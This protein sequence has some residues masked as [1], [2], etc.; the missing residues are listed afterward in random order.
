MFSEMEFI[1]IF[2]SF[3][4][5]FLWKLGWIIGKHSHSLFLSSLFTKTVAK[6]HLFASL[7]LP[8]CPDVRTPRT[9]ELVFIKF[10]IEFCYNSWKHSTL[11]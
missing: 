3:G 4:L 1:K 11:L 6:V 9:A 8:V 10:D 2:M 7:C 5:P